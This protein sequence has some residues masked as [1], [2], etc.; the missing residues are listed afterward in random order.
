MPHLRARSTL[1]A[2]LARQVDEA[3]HLGPV[4]LVL[5][6]R[7]RR[8][9]QQLRRPLKRL[10]AGEE[11]GH[12][13]DVVAVVDVVAQVRLHQLPQ[14]RVF[15]HAG[16]VVV[17]DGFR[18][19]PVRDGEVVPRL[20]DEFGDVE[21]G[22]E[23]MMLAVAEVEADFH[24]V[25]AGLG[26]GAHAQGDP[27]RQR[28]A[29]ADDPGVVREQR[30]GHEAGHERLAVEVIQRRVGRMVDHRH[31]A[32]APDLHLDL[33]IVGVGITP[34]AKH[35]RLLLAHAGLKGKAPVPR[36]RDAERLRLLRRGR[37]GVHAREG[38]L[39]PTF[40][41]QWWGRFSGNDDGNAE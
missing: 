32:D 34:H 9:L 30:V 7:R 31:H 27:E 26:I 3:L 17:P 8:H 38:A 16:L 33:G 15:P 22:G 14:P 28:L 18:P 10:T 23:V 21:R 25:R 4:E 39:H 2:A 24:L 36:G 13:D 35:G 37:R 1:D 41:W 5:V 19:P 40:R 6:L 11:H 12:E 20:D 29:R